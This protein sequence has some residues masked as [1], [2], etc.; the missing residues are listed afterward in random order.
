MLGMVECLQSAVG[1][2]S[3]ERIFEKKLLTVYFWG[4]GCFFLEHASDSAGLSPTLCAL[5]IYLLTYLL[6]SD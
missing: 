1:L 4:E 5:Q 6:R 3:S 2:Y